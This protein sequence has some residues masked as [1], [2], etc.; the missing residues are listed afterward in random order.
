MVLLVLIVENFD[1]SPTIFVFG[2]GLSVLGCL[3]MIYVG[4]ETPL[5]SFIRVF[6]RRS[7]ARFSSACL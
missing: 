6:L 2:G 7:V 5:E 1:S 3:T 4:M